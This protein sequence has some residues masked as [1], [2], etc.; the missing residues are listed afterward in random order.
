M[1]NKGEMSE[2]YRRMY[3]DHTQRQTERDTHRH[4]HAYPAHCCLS[5]HYHFA[6]F[7]FWALSCAFAHNCWCCYGVVYV[8]TVT[9]V[10]V[11]LL[12]DDLAV[13][14]ACVSVTRRVC[15]GTEQN[16]L[17]KAHT[18]LYSRKLKKKKQ[19]TQG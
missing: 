15:D 16:T 8:F 4:T 11:T 6:T 9:S 5:H 13:E 18:T 7:E 1:R 14:S 17:N 2:Q 19:T 10:E 12:S 3:T